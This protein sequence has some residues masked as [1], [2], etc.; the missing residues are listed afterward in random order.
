MPEV[1]THSIVT[2]LAIDPGTLVHAFLDECDSLIHGGTLRVGLTPGELGLWFRK[3]VSVHESLAE[4]RRSLSTR[5]ANSLKEQLTLIE[6]RRL[7]QRLLEVREKLQRQVQFRRVWRQIAALVFTEFE[8]Q[9][10][11]DARG[12]IVAEL[13]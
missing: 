3:L 4:L 10:T 6:Q 7:T 5:D 11:Y 9:R 1:I 12:A 2:T 13:A 8:Q